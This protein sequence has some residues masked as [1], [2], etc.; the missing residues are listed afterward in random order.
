LSPDWQVVAYAFALAV[1]GTV[2][3]TIA[4][5]VRAWKQ[6]LLPSLRSGELGVVAGRSKLSSALVVLQLGFAVLLL[7]SAGLAYRSLSMLG[8][9]D[10][11]YDKANLLLA[12]IDMTEAVLA[13][14]A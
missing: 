13:R 7:T 1:A 9:M 12:S 5:A 8:S 4:P 6:E 11:G 3:F 10:A 14:D 2:A